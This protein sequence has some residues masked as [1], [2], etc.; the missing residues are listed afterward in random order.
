MFETYWCQ[1]TRE[2]I[3]QWLFNELC[4]HCRGHVY[5]PWDINAFELLL[6]FDQLVLIKFSR[7]GGSWQNT[8]VT[9]I[10]FSCKS[11][12]DGLLPIRYVERTCISHRYSLV[13]LCFEENKNLNRLPNNFL[14]VWL[15]KWQIAFAIF[16]HIFYCWQY[17][18]SVVIRETTT[19]LTSFSCNHN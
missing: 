10:G 9:I 19:K 14:L 8:G 15:N 16:M 3:C 4:K 13:S 1:I 2:E 17:Q 11:H 7:G 12:T 18:F 6:H 5:P